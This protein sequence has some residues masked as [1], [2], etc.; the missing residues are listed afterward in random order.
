MINIDPKT[1]TQIQERV[2]NGMAKHVSAYVLQAVI[3]QLEVESEFDLTISALLQATGGDLT[4][5]ES[6]RADQVLT[7]NPD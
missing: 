4:P 5:A 1:L 7:G 3:K 6:A 2:T